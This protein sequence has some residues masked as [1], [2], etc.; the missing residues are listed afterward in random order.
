MHSTGKVLP[1]IVK[2]GT[3]PKKLAN[4]SESMV[5][6]VTMSLRSCLRATTDLSRRLSELTNYDYTVGLKNRY[7]LRIHYRGIERFLS[8]FWAKNRPIYIAYCSFLV[9]GGLLDTGLID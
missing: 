5:A 3:L 9:Q 6:D 1:G 4:F 8:Y 7:D 2:V